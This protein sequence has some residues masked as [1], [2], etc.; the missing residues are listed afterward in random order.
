MESCDLETAN[1]VRGESMYSEDIQLCV[2]EPVHAHRVFIT[3]YTL[4]VQ[5]FARPGSTEQAGTPAGREAV[6]AS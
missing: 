6:A 3:V 5:A 4:Q 1:K 2:R